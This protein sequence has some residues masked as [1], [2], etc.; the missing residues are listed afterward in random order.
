MFLVVPCDFRKWTEVSTET[1]LQDSSKNKIGLID[2]LIVN[3][4]ELPW[5]VYSYSA[6][7]EIRRM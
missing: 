7:K 3:P 6:G 1:Q 2:K 5:Q 4:V